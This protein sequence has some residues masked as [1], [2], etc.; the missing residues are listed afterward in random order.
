MNVRR[1]VRLVSGLHEHTAVVTWWQSRPAALAARVTPAWRR[2]LLSLAAVGA[3][4]AD[5]S[6]V[7]RPARG[8]AAGASVWLVA[9]VAGAILLALLYGCYRTATRF[10]D[11]PAVVRARPQVALHVLFWGAFAVVW[12]TPRD[13][14]VWAS[15]VLAVGA[16]LP[17]FLWRCGYLLKTGQ[18]GR[19]A[20]TRF[21]DHLFY[22]SPVYGGTDTPVGKGYDHLVRH[23]AQSAEALARSQLAGVKLLVLALAWRGVQ[24]VMAGAVY[25]D[26]DSPVTRMLGGYSLS[27]P[28]LDRL[29]AHNV[30]VPLLTAWASLYLELFRE[31]LQH[32]ARGHVI[33]G[34]LR[35]C[36][37]NVFRNTYKP[38]LAESVVEFWNRYYYYFKE[39]LV[40]F[41]FFPTFVRHLRAWP[42]LRIV[43]ATFAA[44][45][46]GNMYYHALQQDRLVLQGD[47]W[48]AWGALHSRVFYCLLLTA[49]LAV[50][51][52][53]EQRRRG[54]TPAARGGVA[55]V[56]RIA[57]V[58]TFFGIIHIWNA[59]A[60]ASFA[61]RTRFFLSLL[62]AT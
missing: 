62:G 23:E 35:L 2:G 50:S 54:R 17:F 30:S 21:A 33:V 10:T 60:H 6:K 37:F 18:R 19:A 7:L 57:T 61:Q 51:M 56:A 34:V 13:G 27:V 55:R 49:G 3:L 43:A 52:L 59:G 29:L 41:F 9:P 11:L 58:W 36:G 31:V 48:Y 1:A 40:D 26:P 16:L 25:G 20:G 15:T 47:V 28:S 42:R 44:A 5:V 45:F 14:S 38:L 24:Q 8:A 22:L 53:R 39:L 46:A 32:A 4:A 12:R